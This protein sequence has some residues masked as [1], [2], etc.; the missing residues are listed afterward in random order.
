MHW[1]APMTAIYAA[2]AAVP[3]LVL[4]YFL[5]LKRH[6][7]FVS[8]T[9]LWKRAIQDMQVNAPFQ[10][11][12]RNLL[13]LLQLLMLIAILLALGRPI[14]SLKT[15]P[16]RRYVLLID[17]S[18]SMNSKDVEGNRLDLARQQAKLLVESLRSKSGLLLKDESDQAMVIAFDEHAKVLC[19]FTSDKKQ[20]L[21]ALDRI[22]HGDGPS[23]L[24][25]A[26]T[27]AHAFAE[28][29][30]DQG[31]TQPRLSSGKLELFSDGRI[32]DLDKIMIA[33]GELNFHSVG[34]AGEN[35][36]VVSM[37]ARRSYERAEEVAIFATL[38]NYTPAEVTCDVQ[39]S[40]DGD[41][42]SVR[43]VTIPPRKTADQNGNAP[44]GT[45][46]VSY[47]LRHAGSGVVEIRQLRVDA[48][49]C[50]D[51]AWSILPP[52]RKL[53][54]LLV[55][56]GNI[57]IS[58]ALKSCP[59]E[60]LDFKT[61][62]QFDS[63]DHS[64][65]SIRQPY[66]VIVLDNHVPPALPRCRYL[67]FGRAPQR[68]GVSTDQRLKNQ[69]VV[70]WRSRHP[71]LQFVNLTN[72]FAVNAWKMTLPRDAEV[73]CEFAGSPGMGVVRRGGSVFLLVGF[74]PMET[75]WPF[76]PGFVMFCYNAMNYLGLESG[77][78]QETDLT[79]GQAIYIDGLPPASEVRIEGPG[80]SNLKLTC[81]ATG[82]L[83][84]PQTD[85]AGVYSVAIENEP[86]MR[87]AVNLLDAKESD[88]E[89]VK[90]ITVS[91]QKIEAR[92]KPPR[93]TNVEL[94]PPLAMVVLVLVCLE[95]FVYNSKVRL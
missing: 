95:W 64:A 70:D 63:L 77:Q 57:A 84:Y 42:R 25:E 85:L 34:R 46:S 82:T 15:G 14:L 26:V 92:A 29:S 30:A 12:R 89:A 31:D 93:L 1:L 71:V 86:P 56:S 60:R 38:A 27:V 2:A 13:L 36:A 6:E 91:G 18:A 45:I 7:Q 22:R 48:L 5:K 65:M 94:W 35:V 80:F 32:R 11:L 19:N 37:Q 40:V 83:R 62:A 74:D 50:D 81:D 44:P 66:D 54:V 75:N 41:V 76:E 33:P 67:V 23:S 28:S 69:V 16:A 90:Q 88:I 39:L 73:L 8:S 51:A 24:A 21:E 4:L 78:T 10:K 61:P 9:F 87:F 58:S 72:L 47:T 52:P 55:T 53:K 20:L 68:I 59:L 43:P 17:R 3:L 49:T 79:V